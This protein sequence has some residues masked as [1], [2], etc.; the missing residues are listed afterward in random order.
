[1]RKPNILVVCPPGHYVLRNLA[2][3]REQAHVWIG[4]DTAALAEH[5]PE[6]EIILYSSLTGQSVDFSEV[7]RHAQ[8]VKW[9]QSLAAGVENLL[10]PE[11]IESPVIVTNA[12]GVFKRSLADF[13][14]FGILFHYKRGR[15]IIESQ[16][17]HR[18]DDFRVDWLPGKIMGVVGY[19]EIGRE[20]ALLAHALGMKI[21][22]IRR[23]P[24]NS[25]GD[26]I[27]DRIFPSESLHDMLREIDVLVAAAPLTKETRHMIGSHEF[28]AMKPS[29]MVINV[30][31]GPVIDQEALISAL[32]QKNIAAA[33]LDVYETEPLPPDNPLWDMDNVL[34][35]PH[36]TDRTENPD[37]LDLA[38]QVFIDNFARYQKGE[39]LL[40]V[41]NKK[42]GY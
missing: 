7:W 9:I 10:I 25:T 26:P 27:L 20:C 15:R 11:L 21:Y 4:N 14:I 35:S 1:M 30:G 18:W 42:A 31:R 33:A 16:R 39:P 37:W 19:G 24:Q 13:V 36:C 2:S 23:N 22:A 38:M 3:I 6:A 34:L 12:R 29:S 32:K 28:G 17:A 41:V 8:N 5:A 40:N